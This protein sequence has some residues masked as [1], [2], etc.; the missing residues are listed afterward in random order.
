MLVLT[1]VSALHSG[2]Y[3]YPSVSATH[4]EPDFLD[5]L[6]G[7]AALDY[8]VAHQQELRRREIEGQRRRYLE[9]QYRL[10][11]EQ[12]RQQAEERRRQAAVEAFLLQLNGFPARR[13]SRHEEVSSAEQYWALQE[14]ERRAALE[15]AAAERARHARDDQLISA[16]LT[17]GDAA[18][19][20]SN[21]PTA[22]NTSSSP[23]S[24][25]P[26]RTTATPVSLEQCIKKQIRTETD[27]ADHASL[28]SLL[29]YLTAQ[30][31][32]SAPIDV[33]G[34]GKARE[35]PTHI[36]VSATPSTSYAATSPSTSS[37][38]PSTTPAAPARGLTLKDLL[39]RRL[40]KEGDA[41][42]QESLQ[43]LFSKLYGA[44]TQPPAQ[45]F[46]PAA[47][48]M[49]DVKGK[50]KAVDEQQ[51]TSAAAATSVPVNIADA[52]SESSEPVPRA[53]LERKP[54]ISPAVAAKIVALLRSR[55]ARRVSLGTIQEVEDALHALEASFVFPEH[56][57][58]SPHAAS[59]ASTPDQEPRELG[60]QNGL[61][62]TS[63]NRAVHA[64][65]H[66]LNGLLARLDA[67]DSRGDLEVRGRRKE[68]VNEIERALREIERR[69]EESRERGNA[70]ANDV[71]ADAKAA[72]VSA[73]PADPASTAAAEGPDASTLPANTEDA[74]A[75]TSVDSAISTSI[76]V[77]S[78]PLADSV[79]V[80]LT[81]IPVPPTSD[82]L[83]TPE[84]ALPAHIASS[85]DESTL[86]V[87]P[88]Q[89]AQHVAPSQE[90][91]PTSAHPPRR[92]AQLVEEHS[93][94]D[95]EHISAEQAA[96]RASAQTAPS[97]LI[98]ETTSLPED[99]EAI[100]PEIDAPEQ[101]VR[102][103][104]ESVPQA[105]QTSL[106]P[107]EHTSLP[108]EDSA[109]SSAA[110]L[111]DDVLSRAPAVKFNDNQEASASAAE[112]EAEQ[113]QTGSAMLEGVV[114]SEREGHSVQDKWETGSLG[115]S[116]SE[117]GAFLLTSSP[118]EVSRQPVQTVSSSAG[119]I[120]GF[121]WEEVEA[122]D[123][124]DVKG[125]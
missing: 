28:E 123:L 59:A 14:R 29:S 49:A 89:E 108:S 83:T 21:A 54:A 73:S 30:K 45:R 42:V 37:L 85:A 34:K 36:P 20:R 53:N 25:L 66:A 55:R 120:E 104:D 74:P 19:P 75:R 76:S 65:E 51:T 48:P 102:A 16:L 26:S 93:Y 52:K 112:A 2:F 95:P 68:V 41:E 70:K 117:G 56:L 72:A 31:T 106:S 79:S 15:Q 121:Q 87:E 33:K 7:Q 38:P 124:V 69:V 107:A 71:E 60:T 23:A 39:Q 91:A 78:T 118:I 50:G 103:P 64:H 86:H 12:R 113:A 94:L 110:L 88:A 3:T 119:E 111:V 122:A 63:S 67:V 105:P 8:A 99:F 81:P 13:T 32:S 116:S 10:L 115:E 35:T 4:R 6:V 11:E 44:P 61:M 98:K 77:D 18:R 22:Q 9:E 17:L 125:P 43:G 80:E 90:D 58:F 46:P 114:D 5:E 84:P 92:A 47:T 96:S 24:S 27:P 109:L 57:D 82:S 101:S 100:L 40:E 97:I 1:P 62:Y